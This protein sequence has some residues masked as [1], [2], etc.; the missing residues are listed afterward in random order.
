MAPSANPI[1]RV[2][3]DFL[4][5][6]AIGEGRE[7]ETCGNLAYGKFVITGAVP[8]EPQKGL[9]MYLCSLTAGRDQGR[10]EALRDKRDT[11]LTVS[12]TWT[13]VEV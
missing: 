13:R 3:L 10:A 1:Y 7:R 5:F 4:S 9:P 12:E 11:P 2:G 8:F 6:Q